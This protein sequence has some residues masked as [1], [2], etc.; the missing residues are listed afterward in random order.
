MHYSE[1]FLECHQSLLWPLGVCDSIKA[2]PMARLLGFGE[3]KKLGVPNVFVEGDSQTIISWG[4]GK[5][6]VSWCLA[7]IIYE[8]RELVSL[9]NCSLFILIEAKMV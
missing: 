7:P 6:N 4:M 9:L 1:S 8:I 5:G 2:E 3:L